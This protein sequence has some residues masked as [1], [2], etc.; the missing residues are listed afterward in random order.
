M[1]D[2]ENRESSRKNNETLSAVKLLSSGNSKTKRMNVDNV[3]KS[4]ALPERVSSIIFHNAG[5]EDIFIRI[6][7]SGTDYFTLKPGVILPK[8][9]VSRASIDVRSTATGSILECILEG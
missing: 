6:N 5:L 8:V 3:V 9:I 7:S 1:V 2:F 4:V